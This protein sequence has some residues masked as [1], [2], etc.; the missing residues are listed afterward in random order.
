MSDD[1][2]ELLARARLAV[3]EA[4]DACQSQDGPAYASLTRLHDQLGIMLESNN[5]ASNDYMHQ[6]LLSPTQSRT[7]DTTSKIPWIRKFNSSIIKV[8][9]G[10]RGADPQDGAPST[11]EIVDV[12]EDYRTRFATMADAQ[13]M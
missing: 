7:D 12:I 5:I 13:R 10:L 11:Q 8:A 4:C 9:Q 2:K 3:S 6:V 1:V